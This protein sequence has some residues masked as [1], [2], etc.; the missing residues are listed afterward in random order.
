M[1]T[2]HVSS[3]FKGYPA[4]ILRYA[5]GK[6]ANPKDWKGPIMAVVEKA[7]VHVVAVAIEFFTAT[8]PTIIPADAD[9][10]KFVVV[11]DGYRAGPAGDH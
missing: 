10:T 3:T 6:V 4:A 7:M 8:V 1:V 5:F 11:S 9:G 2:V